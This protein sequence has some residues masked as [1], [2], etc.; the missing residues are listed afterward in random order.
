MADTLTI[1]DNRTGARDRST[2]A[3]TSATTWSRPGV[4]RADFKY[5]PS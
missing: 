4:N 3:R 2:S 5:D 1:T